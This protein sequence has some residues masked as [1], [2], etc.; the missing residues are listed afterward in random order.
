[1][2]T[3]DTKGKHHGQKAVTL[4]LDQSLLASID[5][6]IQGD[7]SSLPGATLSRQA[8]IKAAIEAYLG[9]VV[10]PGKV[11]INM[12]KNPDVQTV[13]KCL[14]MSEEAYIAD[15]VFK[16]AQAAFTEALDKQGKV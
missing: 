13:A 1:M 6:R 15:R 12:T 16:E 11:T 7:L 3:A 5:E 2:S 10:E 4:W 9:G 8:L 14:G